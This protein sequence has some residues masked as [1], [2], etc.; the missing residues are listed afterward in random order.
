MPPALRSKRFL[1]LALAWDSVK[2]A[3]DLVKEFFF[4]ADKIFKR[5]RD[6]YLSKKCFSFHKVNMD[7]AGNNKDGKPR[8]K[9]SRGLFT[10]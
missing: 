4:A 10:I 3:L 6:E 7:N 1:K 8:W 2:F 5:I 9:M